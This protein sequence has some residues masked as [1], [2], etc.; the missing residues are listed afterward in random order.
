MLFSDRELFLSD[1]SLFVDDDKAY[2]KY[3]SEEPEEKV[4]LLSLSLE[5]GIKS[6]FLLRFNNLLLTWGY[7]EF[8]Y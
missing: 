5:T 3:N 7:E 1:S 2:E 6:D 8:V 4:I